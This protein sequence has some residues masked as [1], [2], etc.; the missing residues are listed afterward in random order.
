MS[1]SGFIYGRYV[2]F[3]GPRKQRSILKTRIQF[4]WIPQAGFDR[5]FQKPLQ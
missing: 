1:L 5:T 2:D 4:C 3:A